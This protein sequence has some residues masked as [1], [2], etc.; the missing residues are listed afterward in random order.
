LKKYDDALTLLHDLMGKPAKLL[1]ADITMHAQRWPDAAKALLD[2]VGQPGTNMTHDQADWLINCAIAYSMAGDLPGLEK[3]K[4]DFGAEIAPLPQ[5][6][7][8]RML[9]EPE[10]TDQL[11][12]ISAVQAKIADVDMFQGFLNNYRKASVPAEGNGK[13][14]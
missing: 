14:P 7:T 10:S 8:F 13:V 2:L 6:D 4:T 11:R 1:R 3:L 5:S 9:T 12:D